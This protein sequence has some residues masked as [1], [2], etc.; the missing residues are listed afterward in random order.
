MPRKKLKIFQPSTLPHYTLEEDTS[1]DN[2]GLMLAHFS[3]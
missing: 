3:L 1:Q 2:F